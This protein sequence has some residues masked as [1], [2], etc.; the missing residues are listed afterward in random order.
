MAMMGDPHLGNPVIHIAGTNGK[1]ST[2]RLATA[3]LTGH[4]LGTGTFTSPHL[5]RL[6]QRYAIHGTTI[7]RDDFVTAVADVAAFSSIYE[8]DEDRLTYFELTTAVA[9]ALFVEK[10]V[11]VAVVEVGLGGRLDA[12]NIVDGDIAVITDIGL[13][14]TEYLGPD[15][16]SIAAEKV[17]IAKPGSIL[18][19]GELVPD[20][21][22]VVAAWADDIGVEHRRAGDDF[23]VDDADLTEGGWNLGVSGIHGD[24]GDLFLPLYGRHQLTN[25]T[26][27][28]ASVESLLGR[29]LDEEALRTSLAG[30]VNPGRFEVI[31][32]DPPLVIDG[33]HNG[34][35]FAALSATL[36]EV[37]PKWRWT[38]VLGVMGDKDVDLMME[39]IGPRLDR[40]VTT[41]IDHERAVPAEVLAETVRSH[42]SVPVAAVPDPVEA[43]RSVRG[44]GPMV[45]AGSLYLAGAV[46]PH[47]VGGR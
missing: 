38:L 43:V 33:A 42:V 7:T 14:H 36:G 29:E 4:T 8:A 44:E 9:F 5:E 45:V 26:L 18:V 3:I 17:A 35:G 11:D 23:G 47:L 1:T 32:T 16:A 34:H 13:D 2:S 46:R 28:I 19:T 12:T 10:A 15:L 20:A 41:A 24:Y 37:F 25:L 40:V 27:A 6:E 22:A 21:A 39:T 30:V 31:A